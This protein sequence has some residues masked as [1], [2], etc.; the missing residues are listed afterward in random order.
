VVWAAPSVAEER[1]HMV[2]AGANR[3]SYTDAIQEGR[4]EAGGIRAREPLDGQ[5]HD[6]TTIVST[7]SYA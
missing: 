7:C 1:G 5:L 2:E 6:H 3:A 4:D